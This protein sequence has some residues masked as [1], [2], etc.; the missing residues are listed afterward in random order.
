MSP[1]SYERAIETEIM[2]ELAGGRALQ[3]VFDAWP[4][5]FHSLVRSPQCSWQALAKILH[6]KCGFRYVNQ[7]LRRHPILVRT[8]L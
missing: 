2:P 1:W 5:L 4:W 6:G 7:V 8:A 3:P